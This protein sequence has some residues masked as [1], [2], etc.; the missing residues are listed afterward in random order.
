[1]AV[2]LAHRTARRASDRQARAQGQTELRV[3]NAVTPFAYCGLLRTAR[4]QKK[5]GPAA[6]E[7]AGPHFIVP[8]GQLEDCPKQIMRLAMPRA[9]VEHVAE[10]RGM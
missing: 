7:P 6:G 1:M 8:E 4:F 5:A 2:Y 10:C 3:G 9:R